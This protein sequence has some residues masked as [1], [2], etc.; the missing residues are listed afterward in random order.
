LARGTSAPPEI[1]FTAPDGVRHACWTLADPAAVARVRAAFREL[2]ALYIADGHHRTA[3]AARVYRAR[4]GA[5]GSACFLAVLFPHDQVQILPYHRAVK[6]LNG[7]TPGTFLERLLRVGLVEEAGSAAPRGQGEVTFHLDACWRRFRFKPELS[8]VRDPLQRLDVALLQ[9]HVLGP[10]LGIDDPRRSDRIQFIGGIR[11]TP[12]L[13]RLVRTGAAAVAFAMYPTSVEDLL[14]VADAGG[15][16]PPK[17]TWFEPKL[18][19][20]LFSHRV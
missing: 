6:D 1:D 16:M 12:E 9:R 5:G 20:G 4:R 19:D 11:G 14:A 10:V 3:A 15:I 13:E 7:L 17:S 8:A 2:P 18:R